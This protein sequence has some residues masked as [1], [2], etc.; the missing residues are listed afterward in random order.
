MIK[1]TSN[2]LIF[3]K[4]Y[5]I[6][7]GTMDTSGDACRAAPSVEA[8]HCVKS[9]DTRINSRGRRK[10]RKKRGRKKY[11]TKSQNHETKISSR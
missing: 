1:W 5:K 7:V 9:P 6:E 10:K 2:F 4:L 8:H 11:D 3:I